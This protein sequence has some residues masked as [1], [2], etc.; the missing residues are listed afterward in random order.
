M[1]QERLNYTA[2]FNNQIDLDTGAY[3]QHA[4]W[5]IVWPNKAAGVWVSCSRAMQTGCQAI[6]IAQQRQCSLRA[7][8][9]CRAGRVFYTYKPFSRLLLWSVV[10]MLS[11]RLSVGPCM[12]VTYTRTDGQT[13]R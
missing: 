11:V 8:H 7:A 3:A 13:D 4:P 9:N 6:A 10:P 1:H 2:D 5:R 12:Y